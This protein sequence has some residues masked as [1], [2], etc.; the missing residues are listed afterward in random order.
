MLAGLPFKEETV[1]T[2][3]DMYQTDTNIY[4]VAPVPMKPFIQLQVEDDWSDYKAVIF[5]QTIPY[6]FEIFSFEITL[7]ENNS[8]RGK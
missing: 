6:P 3:V 1:K 5:R 7:E 8:D 4:G 2:L